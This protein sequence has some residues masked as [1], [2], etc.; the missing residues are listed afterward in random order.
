MDKEDGKI[1]RRSMV[2][3][4][5]SAAAALHTGVAAGSSSEKVVQKGRL[6]QSVCK[7]CYKGM[8]VADLAEN[9]SR[10][11][12][13]GVD[14]LEADDWG[15]MK[16][17][18]IVCAVGTGVNPIEDGINDPAN[19]GTIEANFRRLLPLAK[20]YGVPNVIVFSGN[21][22]GMED[23]RAWDNSTRLLNKVKA[24]AEDLGVTIVMELLNS[25]VDHPDYHCDKTPW[26]VEVIKRVDSPRVKLLYDIYHMQIMEG[27]VIRTI[28]E[29]IPYIAHF[30]T[31]GNPGRNE[32]DET[33]ELNYR[34]IAEA[35]LELGFDGYFAHEFI[36]LRDPMTS[37]REAAKL[38]DV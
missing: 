28:R 3:G 17:Y 19:H 18:G 23:E 26:G 24:Q 34:A 15:L 38:C 6:K 10:I 11:G 14:L 33:Q 31:G 9:A 8:R 29:N 1:S 27:D 35:I 12:L 20:Q 30:H 16:K 22:H 4:A 7:W 13:A 5:M 36:P 25:K 21:R 2:A 37:L 32:I